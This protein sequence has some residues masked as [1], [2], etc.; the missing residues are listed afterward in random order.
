MVRGACG[1]NDHP[2]PL[3][4][5]QVYR[6]MS[7]Y[8]LVKPPKGSNVEK[9]D[10]YNALLTYHQ[11]NDANE[12]RKQWN[13]ALDE[14]V[15]KISNE[16]GTRVIS[17]EDHDYD[18]KMTSDWALG[19]FTGFVTKHMKN[20]TSCEECVSTLMNREPTDAARDA[21]IIYL[22]Q[23]G[24][25]YPSNHLFELLRLMEVTILETV[26]K[27]NIHSATILHIAQNLGKKKIIFVGC[28]A[29]EVE[30]TRK[31]IEY[32]LISR[33][34]I[35]CKRYNQINDKIKQDIRCKR[36]SYKL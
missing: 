36:K 21:L 22:N 6:L 7:F 32:F 23:G 18:I 31:I 27:E 2:D 15:N 20:W 34:K 4:F 12:A 35:L 24:L 28:D 16:D 8:S 26:G 9:E 5:A 17:Q 19:Y 3:L 11:T 30:V 1:C 10:M 29:H 14:I 33:M 25:Q 13:T